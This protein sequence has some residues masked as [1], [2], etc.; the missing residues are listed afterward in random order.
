MNELNEL[1]IKSIHGRVAH[2][3]YS[4]HT[5]HTLLKHTPHERNKGP[6]CGYSPTFLHADL[7]RL[8]P[9]MNERHKYN[10]RSEKKNKTVDKTAQMT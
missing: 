1:V 6:T 5:G 7:H 4:P 8:Q 2:L 10:G 3:L 9:I